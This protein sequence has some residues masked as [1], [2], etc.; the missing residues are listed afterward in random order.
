MAQLQRSFPAEFEDTREDSEASPESYLHFGAAS[1]EPEG[2]EELTA[3]V[4]PGFS[5]S[6]IN[7]RTNGQKKPEYQP[8][9]QQQTYVKKPPNAFMLFLQEQRPHV[10]PDACGTM[11]VAVFLAKHVEGYVPKPE[12]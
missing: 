2:R 7:K 10:K 11:S 5:A 8:D 3:P 1:P 12:G 4:S 9:G 6:K